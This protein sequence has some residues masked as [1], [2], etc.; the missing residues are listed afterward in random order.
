MP[1]D[2]VLA[3]S[4]RHFENRE[5]NKLNADEVRRLVLLLEEEKKKEPVHA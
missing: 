2:Y 3:F 4:Q 1:W 5:P